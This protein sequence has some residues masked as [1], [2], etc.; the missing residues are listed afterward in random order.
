MKKTSIQLTK[1]TSKADTDKPVSQSRPL[2]NNYHVSAVC[3]TISKDHTLPMET[4]NKDH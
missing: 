2:I 4:Y 3:D 1:I